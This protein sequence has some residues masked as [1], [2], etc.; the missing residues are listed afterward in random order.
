MKTPAQTT[1]TFTARLQMYSMY[2]IPPH[3]LLHFHYLM[4]TLT[5][6]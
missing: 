1:L 4:V 2:R 6:A 5:Q 3:I